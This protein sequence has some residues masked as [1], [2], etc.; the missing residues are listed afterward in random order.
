MKRARMYKKNRPFFSPELCK[1]ELRYPGSELEL[2][3]EATN[4]KNTIKLNLSPY[5]SGEILEVGAGIGGSTKILCDGKQKRWVCLEPDKQN[6][7]KIKHEIEFQNLPSCCEIRNATISDLNKDEIFDSILYIDVLEHIEN[8]LMELHQA[9]KHLKPGAILAILVP[10]HLYL[11]SVFDAAIGHYRRYNQ[12][13][14]QQIIPLSLCQKEI[15]YL[16]CIGLFASLANK[17]LLK[18]MLPDKN[19]IRI[20]DKAMVPISRKLDPIFGY[21]IGKSLLGIWKKIE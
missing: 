14:L 8:D 15:K 17:I 12:K 5:L 11:Y 1:S 3:R 18:K 19:Q 4:W 2:F 13:Q 9:E 16:D 10:A 7:K 6:V 20:W 21:R